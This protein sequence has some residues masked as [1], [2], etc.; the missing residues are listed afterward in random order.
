[1]KKIKKYKIKYHIKTSGKLIT[2]GFDKN[3]PMPVKRVFFLYGKKNT[4]RGNH[5]HKKCSQLFVPIFGKFI[6]D[7]KTPKTNKK[8]MLSHSKNVALYVPPKYWC[9]VKF[10]I[11]NSV[12]MVICDQLYKANDYIENFNEYKKYLRKR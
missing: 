3:F 7:I 5:A 2:M 8:I 9:S 6:L 11:K 10:L 4:I 1:M 12:L